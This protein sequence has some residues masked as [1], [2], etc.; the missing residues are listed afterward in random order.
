MS[1]VDQERKAMDDLRSKI[2]VAEIRRKYKYSL[3]VIQAMQDM[4]WRESKNRSDTFDPDM[5]GPEF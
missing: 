3:P 2:P 5:E 1:R 4:I